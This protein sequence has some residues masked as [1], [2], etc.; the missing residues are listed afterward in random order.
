MANWRVAKSLT[1][2]RNQIN[3]RYPNRSK[4][5]DGFIGDEDH[6][7]RNSDHNPWYNG[8]VTAG[9]FTHDP[10]NGIDIDDFT[11][12][13]VASRDSRIKYIIANGMI[14]SGSAG[15]SPWV[16]RPYNGPS[17][18]RHHFHLSVKANESCDSTTLWNIPS[19]G[20][21]VALPAPTVPRLG[22]TLEKGSKG[23][24]VERWQAHCNDYYSR[25]RPLLIEDGDFGDKTVSRTIEIQRFRGINPDGR[26]GPATRAAT[27]FR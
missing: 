6:S 7:N 22:E 16:W 11:D 17:P 15:P 25:F 8:I 23:P 13:L 2:L 24:E 19:L 9:D 18:H 12:E 3:A 21:A 26:V 4:V 14:C 20:G 10:D 27:N 5:S 1:T